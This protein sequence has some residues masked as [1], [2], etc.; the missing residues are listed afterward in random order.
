MNTTQTLRNQVPTKL[1]IT[2]EDIVPILDKAIENGNKK[3]EQ[4]MHN[5]MKTLKKAMMEEAQTHG[6]ELS[7][8]VKQQML[9]IQASLALVLIGM[10]QMTGHMLQ[11]VLKII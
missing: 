9:D 11:L 7:V 6:D 4:E 1:S 3:L 8:K 2:K 10:Q 5:K